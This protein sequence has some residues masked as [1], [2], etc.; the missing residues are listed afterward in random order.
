MHAP[1]FHLTSGHLMHDSGVKINHMFHDERFWLIITLAIL[2][3]LIGLSVWAGIKGGGMGE[4]PITPY[5]PY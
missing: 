1:H 2:A 4:V 3:G 5:F